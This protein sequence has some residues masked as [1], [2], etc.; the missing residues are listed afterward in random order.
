VANIVLLVVMLGAVYSHYALND[1]L[2]KTMP[3][4]VCASLLT[5]RLLIRK[6]ACSHDASCQRKS[7][8][9]EARTKSD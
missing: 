3:A 9:G 6:S 1:D 2:E 7:A 8:A 4:I 5:L